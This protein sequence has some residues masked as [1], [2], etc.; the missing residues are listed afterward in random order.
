[1][2]GQAELSGMVK[3][4]KGNPFP[5]WCFDRNENGSAALISFGEMRGKLAGLGDLDKI[6]GEDGN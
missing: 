6:V 3:F 2:F 5:S 4:S 1:M